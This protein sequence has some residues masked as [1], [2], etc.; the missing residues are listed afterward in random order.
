MKLSITLGSKGNYALLV[1]R[2][3]V[4]NKEEFTSR[5]MEA[6][7]AGD[8]Y[9][10]P[11]LCSIKFY[12]FCEFLYHGDPLG[13]RRMQKFREGSS[14]LFPNHLQIAA[15]SGQILRTYA[16]EFLR[17]NTI[18]G[19]MYF[20]YLNWLYYRHQMGLVQF[21]TADFTHF[22]IDPEEEKKHREII[23][24]NLIAVE[25]IF[26][27]FPS[28]LQVPGVRSTTVAVEELN[29]LFREIERQRNSGINWVDLPSSLRFIH[30][31]YPGKD[32]MERTEHISRLLKFMEV[33][34]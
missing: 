6:Q 13:Y 29:I 4:I 18:L 27:S 31:M 9:Y 11:L 25:S 20:Q 8:S 12:S 19:E 32:P 15:E 16:D 17:S 30:L 28:N 26:T 2:S 21:G 5:M 3:N 22:R 34:R 33:S 23:D 14:N 7:P 24:H 10:R 1:P